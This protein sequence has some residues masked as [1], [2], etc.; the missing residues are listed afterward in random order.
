M[1]LLRRRA[2]GRQRDALAGR[3]HRLLHVRA[4][5]DRADAD[6]RRRA[7]RWP[8]GRRRRARGCS[9]SST[10]S[11]G[12]SRRRARRRCPPAAGACELR[13]VTFAYGERRAVAAR[14]RPGRRGRARTVALVGATGSGKTTLVQLLP[15]L[16]DPQRGRRADRRRRRARRSTW[17]RCGGRSR[18]STTTRSCS[19]DTV[20][21]NIAYAR[22]DATREEIERA[23][24]RA[25]AAG[26]I[27]ELPDGYDTRVGER[28]L[29]LSR[30]PAPADRDRPRVPG[31]PADPHPR[32]RHVVGRRLDRA[33]DQGR[34]ARG[35]GGPHDVR[36]RPP[37]VHHRAGRR[38]RRARARPRSSRAGRTTSC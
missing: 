38:H 1:I 9:R 27:A 35:D 6:A 26:F 19:R 10:A 17:S 37:A 4:D 33:R 12:S 5:A 32:R 25:Q 22:P 11:R 7:R 36:D 34:A 3:L 30:R 16:Y 13:D 21:G 31:R 23:A 14:R 29:T 15:R 28:G 18:S 20:A 24:E 8:S 2:P